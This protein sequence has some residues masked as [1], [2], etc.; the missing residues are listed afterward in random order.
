MRALLSQSVTLMARGFNTL[1][2]KQWNERF[3]VKTC[4]VWLL[5]SL[6]NRGNLN[7]TFAVAN[8]EAGISQLSLA[9]NRH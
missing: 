5:T 1:A 6:T 9:T 4:I 8:E 2:Q 7:K 3:I